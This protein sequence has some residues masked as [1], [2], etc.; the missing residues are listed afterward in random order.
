MVGT[1]NNVC[2]PPFFPYKPNKGK[3]KIYH[4]SS[5]SSPLYLPFPPLCFTKPNVSR[6]EWN[7]LEGTL[8]PLYFLKISNFYSQNWEE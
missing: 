7:K 6:K 3:E 4:F 5:L 2:C 8:I 1:T